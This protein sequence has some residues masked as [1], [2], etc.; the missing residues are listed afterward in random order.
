[1]TTGPWYYRLDGEVH[2]P[3]TL[4]Q[5]EKLIRGKAV[6]PETEVSNDGQMW[7]TLRAAMSSTS[8]A[9][10]DS[11]D[12]MNAPTLIPGQ[13]PRLERKPDPPA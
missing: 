9:P 5:F 1:M 4:A 6:S 13:L 10:A 7:Q 3:F 2:G 12:W 8:D 11:K